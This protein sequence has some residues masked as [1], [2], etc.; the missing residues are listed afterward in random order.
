M[1]THIVAFLAGLTV[2]GLYAGITLRDNLSSFVGSVEKLS[3]AVD[4]VTKE[5]KRVNSL[6][7]EFARLKNS[8]QS[9]QQ[10]LRK[11]EIEINRK[12]H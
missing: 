9:S 3:T 1:R 2:A 5:L 10:R 8:E 6:E 4:D 11:L 7:E 12:G